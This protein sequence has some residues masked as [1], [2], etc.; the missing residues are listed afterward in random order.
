MPSDNFGLQ[1][2]T[3]ISKYRRKF[4]WEGNYVKLLE[5]TIDR[6]LKLDKHAM[7]IF[8]KASQK[9]SALCRIA[10]LLYLKAG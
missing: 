7:K 8:I 2:G 3:S 6:D 9:I 10:K 4:N 5:I 1:T